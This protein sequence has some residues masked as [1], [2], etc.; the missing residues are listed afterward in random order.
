VGDFFKKTRELV[1]THPVS[2][3][4]GSEA[5]EY[6]SIFHVIPGTSETCYSQL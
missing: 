5:V 3:C 1:I 4:F 6:S 2:V